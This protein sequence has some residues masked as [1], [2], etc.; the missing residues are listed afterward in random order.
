[1]V[2]FTAL[3]LGMPLPVIGGWGCSNSETREG[4]GKPRSI[5]PVIALP[6]AGRFHEARLHWGDAPGRC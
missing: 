5:P 2:L 1:M 3:Q 6:R 4:I